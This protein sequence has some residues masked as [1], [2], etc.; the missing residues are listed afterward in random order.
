M[1]AA[2]DPKAAPGLLDDPE[3]KKLMKD[4]KIKEALESKDFAELR[5]TLEALER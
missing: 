3:L 1:E 4:P 5:K 2:R